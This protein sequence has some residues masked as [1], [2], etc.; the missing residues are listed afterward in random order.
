[1][2]VLKTPTLV[3]ELTSQRI[4]DISFNENHSVALNQNNQVFTWG[5]SLDGALGYTTEKECQLKP[6]LIEKAFSQVSKI[7]TGKFHTAIICK[8]QGYVCGR[9]DYSCLGLNEK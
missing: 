4:T 9:N 7:T 3:S 5:F 2:Q 1:M 6:R 8:E